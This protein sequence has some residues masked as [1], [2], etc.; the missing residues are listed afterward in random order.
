[1]KF[2]RSFRY[3]WNGLQYCYETQ[4]NFRVELVVLLM[5]IVAGFMLRISNTEWLF[6]IGCSMLVLALE[7]MN[8]AIEHLCDTITKDFHP[9]IKI[10]KDASAAAV[11]LAATGSVVA[12]IVIFSPKII[13]LLKS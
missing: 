1:M 9:A 5:V 2:T 6:I 4:L 7:L 12:G 10:I 3:A 13:D 8:T 11:L